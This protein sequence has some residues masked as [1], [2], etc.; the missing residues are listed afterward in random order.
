MA[1]AAIDQGTTATKAVTAGAETA[2]APEAEASSETTGDEA[3]GSDALVA[4]KFAPL[5]WRAG[6]RGPLLDA[7]QRSFDRLRVD[8]VA[9]YQIHFPPGPLP[10]RAWLADLAT[11]YE[12]GLIGRRPETT[13][14]TEVCRELGVTLIAYSPLAQ[15]LLTG[16]YTRENPPPGVRGLRFRGSATKVAAMVDELTAV[17]AAHDRTPGQTAGEVGA[18]DRVG[19]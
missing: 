1:V 12:R 3:A 7:L 11:A 14:L 10:D 8:R 18:L 16:K 19:R 15:G 9:L 13:G 2:A 17:G 6:R 4:T 5:P